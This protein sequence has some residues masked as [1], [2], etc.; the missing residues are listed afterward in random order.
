MFGTFPPESPRIARANH[1][2]QRAGAAPDT[3][4]SGETKANQLETLLPWNWKPSKPA[5]SD[6]I[7]PPIPI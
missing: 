6:L 7:R 5:D 4:V 2:I 3:I 1:Y